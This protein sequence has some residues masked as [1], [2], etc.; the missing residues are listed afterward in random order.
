MQGMPTDEVIEEQ[1]PSAPECTARPQ[2]SKG[3]EL[4]DPNIPFKGPQKVDGATGTPE[5]HALRFAQMTRTTYPAIHVAAVRNAG[6]YILQ[7]MLVSQPARIGI[8]FIF[9]GSIG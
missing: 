5:C 6:I 7:S 8:A 1:N 4:M 3:G 9:V 2:R